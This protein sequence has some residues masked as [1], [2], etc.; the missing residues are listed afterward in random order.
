MVLHIF[1]MYIDRILTTQ[2]LD[3]THLYPVIVITG[4]RQVGKTTLLEHSF[5]HASYV[6]LDYMQH[7]EMAESRPQEFL[8]Q[9]NT[10]LIIDEIQYALSLLRHIKTQVDR[11]RGQTGLY[12]ITGSQ[13]FLLMKEVSESLAGRAA[14][15][16]LQ[17][18]S[19]S[20]W[21]SVFGAQ[22]ENQ[23]FLFRGTYPGLWNREDIAQMNHTR[24]YQNY[25]ATY[26][27]RDI[28]SIYNVG[29]LRDFDRFLRICASRVSQR[30]NL[31]DMAR[32]IGIAP[33]TA[34]QWLNVLETSHIIALLEPYYESLG[35]RLA[36]S[37]KL[38]FYDTGL[39]IFLAG[40]SNKEAL[41]QSPMMGALWE[42]H[43]IAQ[44]LRWKHWEQPAAQLWYWQ[45]QQKREVD[46]IVDINGLLYP[47]E[48]KWKEIPDRQ[49]TRG[50]RAFTDFY[51]SKR[52]GQAYIAC[53]SKQ[54]FMLGETNVIALSGWTTWELGA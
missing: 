19:F 32:D 8:E 4:P 12:F 42:N 14:V 49:D 10:P 30:V 36:K 1:Y 46:L 45:D 7:A 52:I 23:D 5:P 40:F 28:R 31:S 35:K 13:N 6:S 20:E 21:E 2:I 11:H 16:T 44:W 50:I 3:L 41:K 33:N 43:V 39:A 53:L 17:G 48:C 34:R 37:P 22:Y 51:G 24:W 25:L 27:E 18:L 38:Y 15:L 47:I 29:N 9:F 26:L 54:S